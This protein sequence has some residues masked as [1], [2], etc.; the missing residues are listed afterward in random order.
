MRRL[1]LAVL[2]V[3]AL[4]ACG[5]AAND[6]PVTNDQNVVLNDAQANYAFEN[7]GEGPMAMERAD[8]NMMMTNDGMMMNGMDANMAGNMMP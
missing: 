4:A 7:D 1:M 5:E 3:A 6:I 2:P 8:D